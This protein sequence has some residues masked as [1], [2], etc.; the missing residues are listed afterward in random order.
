MALSIK[1]A[2]VRRY[3]DIVHL[4]TKYGNSD[5]LNASGLE[6]DILLED[7]GEDSEDGSA[8]EELAD[9]LEAL[10]PTF[11]KLGQLLSTRADLLPV[12]YLRALSRLQDDVEP[13]PL[14]KVEE[15]VTSELGV[16]I[17]K[18][19]REFD[20]EPMAAASLGQVHRAVLRDGR[21]VAVKVQR[22]DIR[23]RI[24]KDLE[25][26]DEI[27]GF[28]DGHTDAGQKY[29]FSDMLEQFRKSLLRELDYR[30]EA[31]NLR[32]L[33]SNLADY[34]RIIVPQPIDDY[35]SSRVLTME[36]V[37]G[38]KVTDLNPVVRTE[39]EGEELAEQL[40]KAYLDQILVDGFVH[41]DPHPGNIFITED[42]RLA[43]LDLGMVARIEPRVQERL[44]RLLLAIVEG[45]GSDVADISREIGVE[46]E[47]FDGDRFRREVSDLV[48]RYQHATL[49]E[50]KVGRIVIEIA[51]ISGDCGV[52]AAPELTMLG[53]ALLNLDEVSR[54]L[55]PDFDPNDVVRRHADSIM[56]RRMLKRLSPAN[57]F[58]TAL[59]M[60]EFVQELPSRLNAVLGKLAN[61]EFEVQVSSIDE[62]RLLHN[63]HTIGNR[64]SLSMVLAALIIGAAMLMRV[65]TAFTILG[66]PGIAMILFLVAAAF[67]FAL[68]LSIAFGEDRSPTRKRRG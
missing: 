4:L 32:T 1:P 30:Q 60:N 36:Y 46:S 14:E 44:L 63:L 48:L 27:A 21:S 2:H 26:L 49:K 38:T 35:C 5:V 11:V 7:R 58:S 33:G 39:L 47:A 56:R 6:E 52:R 25:A 42:H 67:G 15:I 65:E 24:R 64:L 45:E 3:R 29:A 41:A 20:S 50:I 31:Q 16:R 53:K 40:S 22:P 13:F 68:V 10:G 17:S 59:E 12:T 62:V 28:I 18:G 37:R 54:V 57:V 34:D 23:E 9:D 8:P 51:R 55:A 66:Y 43:L 19:F 61:N